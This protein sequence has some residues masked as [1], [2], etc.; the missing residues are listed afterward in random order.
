MCLMVALH[1][2]TFNITQDY[3]STD[4]WKSKDF[5]IELCDNQDWNIVVKENIKIISDG[6]I[7]GTHIYCGAQEI[8][9]VTSFQI[10][11]NALTS[12]VCATLHIVDPEVCMDIQKD[13]VKIDA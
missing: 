9:G 4:V 1:G 3:L 10:T 8:K 13:K 5:S 12:N 11:A 6:T 7:S 2:K